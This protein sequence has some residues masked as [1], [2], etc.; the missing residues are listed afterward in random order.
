M[1]VDAY[2]DQQVLARTIVGEARGEPAQGKIAVAFV[3]KNRMLSR[4]WLD[5]VAACCLQPKQ[6]SCWNDGDPNRTVLASANLHSA[7]QYGDCWEIAGAVL[8]SS[9]LTDPTGGAFYYLTTELI[10]RGKA[11]SW[12]AKVTPT[13]RIGAHSFATLDFNTRSNDSLGNPPGWP[14]GPSR[15]AQDRAM[16][17]AHERYRDALQFYGRHEHWMGQMESGPNR[18]LT[19]I[20]GDLGPDG[21]AVAEAALK[22]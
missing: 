12:W 17:N 21:W 14:D 4:R 7:T 22:E 13:V 18:L 11:P 15:W 6:A 20:A 16:W 3:F 10:Q 5:S 19:A 9:T 2:W 1:N 8:Y